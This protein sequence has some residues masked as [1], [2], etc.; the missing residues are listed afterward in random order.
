VSAIFTLFI[1]SYLL[2]LKFEE[3]SVYM[4]ISDYIDVLGSNAPAFYFL[5]VGDMLYMEV[6]LFVRLNLVLTGFRVP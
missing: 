6:L 1:E 4:A 2:S 3:T 5:V